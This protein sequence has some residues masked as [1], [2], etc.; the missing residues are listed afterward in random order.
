MIFQSTFVEPVTAIRATHS[1]DLRIFINN[2]PKFEPHLATFR[3]TGQIT[4]KKIQTPRNKRSLDYTQRKW[5]LRG[6]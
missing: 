3:F 4:A 5:I 2:Q 1:S 6:I